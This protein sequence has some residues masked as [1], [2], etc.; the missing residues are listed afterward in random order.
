[1]D[2]NQRISLRGLLQRRTT[3]DLKRGSSIE[4]V[5]ENNNKL[6]K[7]IMTVKLPKTTDT[8]Y[9]DM[10]SQIENAPTL[11]IKEKKTS[12]AKTTSPLIKLSDFTPSPSQ[13]PSSQQPP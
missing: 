4:T 9:Y 12:K 10:I 6:V 7:A 13:P 8:T 5:K 1:L 3:A 2:E 11:I